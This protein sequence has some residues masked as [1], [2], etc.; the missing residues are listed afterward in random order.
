LAKNSGNQ[1]FQSISK[2]IKNSQEDA[3][4]R[5]GF[6]FDGPHGSAMMSGPGGGSTDVTTFS[7][8]DTNN[9]I[10]DTNKFLARLAE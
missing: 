9:L 5:S 3:L 8:G 6:G 2:V 7:S 4:L 1:H 10:G